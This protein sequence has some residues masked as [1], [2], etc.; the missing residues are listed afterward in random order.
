[1]APIPSKM[2]QKSAR[3]RVLVVLP[4][5]APDV[6]ASAASGTQANVSTQEAE[7]DGPLRTD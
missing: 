5:A 7:S 3:L 1:M 6:H 2:V 4:H